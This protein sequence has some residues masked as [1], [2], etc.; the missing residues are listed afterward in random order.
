M[1]SDRRT[2]ITKPAVTFR[3]IASA[4]K[5]N[6]QKQ[7]IAACRNLGNSA[8]WYSEGADF[9][10]QTEYRHSDYDS[11]WRSSASPGK[12]RDARQITPR[13]IPATYPTTH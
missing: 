4:L 12:F 3:K 8:A 9:D 6:G 1:H 13:P 2:D 5:N 7:G 10:P 11:P